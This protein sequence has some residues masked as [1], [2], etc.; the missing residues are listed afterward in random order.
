MSARQTILVA[1]DESSMRQNL[2]ELLDEEGF[3]LIEAADGKAAVEQTRLC[4]PD[5]VLLDINL[6][7]MDGLA[8]LRTIKSELPETV[9]IVF[10]AYGTSERAIEAMKAGAY[11]YLEKP[12][13]LDEFLLIVRRSLHYRALLGEVRHLRNQISRQNQSAVSA[14]IVGTSGK[15]QE[16]FKHI[17]RIAPTDT[18]VLI[19]GESGT[20]KELVADALQRHSPRN[21]KPFIKV[22]CG[23]LPE[24]LLESEMFG[25]ERGAFTG[26]VATHTGRFELADG[27]TLFLDEV[28]AMTPAL[29]VKLL[30]VL[31][32]KQ[33]ERVGG[34][35]TLTADVRVIAATNKD[36]GREVMEGRFREDLFYRLNILHISIPPLR[37]HPE[38]I[39]FLVEHFLDKYAPGRMVF[40][41]PEVFEKFQAYA[42]PGN[43]R[44]LENVVQRALVMA[45]GDLIT[46]DT[47]PLPLRSP[48]TP[49][50]EPLLQ[51][52]G[53]ALKKVVSQ[54]ERDL[55]VRALEQTGGNKSR[56]AQLLQI[57]RRQLFA[58]LKQLK[59]GGRGGKKGE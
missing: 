43:V 59:I 24:T 49:P 18:T 32:N 19:Q 39:P 25:H 13:D 21:D 30:R 47:L 15:M 41:S 58:K 50:A 51:E 20:G 4:K 8:A 37:D 42:W 35:Q 48:R 6:P 10:T 31:Q 22:N 14:S 45:Q 55:I 28:N 26:A 44:E 57:H 46:V 3:A 36:L 40:V 23:A 34:K 52:N 27:G 38:D 2:K 9:V 29:Q 5:L 16:I 17:G 11:D 53:F 1:D 33:F 54:V 12:F 7:E 56:A